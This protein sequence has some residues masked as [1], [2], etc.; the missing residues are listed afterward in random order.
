MPPTTI[1]ISTTRMT[2][3]QMPT[4][5]PPCSF[6]EPTP[7]TGTRRPWARASRTRPPRR[8]ARRGSR[9]D[10]GAGDEYAVADGLEREA[11]SV[12][13]QP[14]HHPRVENVTGESR[15]LAVHTEFLVE[16]LGFELQVVE[17]QRASKRRHEVLVLDQQ[18]RAVGIERHDRA[19][20]PI[21]GAILAVLLVVHEVERDHVRLLPRAPDHV[22]H[23]PPVT[24]TEQRE[25]VPQHPERIVAA[26]AEA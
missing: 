4:G 22:L 3:A 15:H 26:V 10:P 12:V 7:D 14:L 16:R 8:A 21:V 18:T 25:G 20:E 2:I 13:E 23:P 5:S 11:G 6:A 24:P 9:L 17:R 19:V 1:K